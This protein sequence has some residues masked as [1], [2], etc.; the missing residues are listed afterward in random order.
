MRPPHP[1]ARS[2]VAVGIPALVVTLGVGGMLVTVPRRDGP[3]VA[4]SAISVE[5]ELAPG[6]AGTWGIVLP[7]N[8]T[9]SSITIESAEAVDARGVEV[10][11]MLVNDPAR[12]GGISSLD[13]YP[14][15][16]VHGRAS[17]RV[18]CCRRSAPMLPI[19]SS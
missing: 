4:P 19:A 15:P 17:W 1:P 18:P 5:F 10:V 16:G 12:D 14:P 11:G 6:Q 13:V 9:L 3:L 8:P 2:L 7:T